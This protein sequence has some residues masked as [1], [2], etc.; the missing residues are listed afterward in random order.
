MWW[1]ELFRFLA[2]LEPCVPLGDDEEGALVERTIITGEARTEFLRLLRS[3]P[4]SELADH[5][6]L[7]SALRILDDHDKD[8]PVLLFGWP[9]KP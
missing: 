1:Q 6:S 2:M 9:P 3:A 5:R 4:A 7:R 8:I